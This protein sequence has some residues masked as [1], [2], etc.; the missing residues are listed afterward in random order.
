MS[1]RMTAILSTLGLF[2]ALTAGSALDQQDKMGKMEGKDK[3]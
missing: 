2:A 1:T 3:K